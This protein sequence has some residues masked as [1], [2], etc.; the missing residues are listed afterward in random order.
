MEPNKTNNLYGNEF[1][2]ICLQHFPKLKKDFVST[3]SD[4]R[5]FYDTYIYARFDVLNHKM[6]IS[7]DMAYKNQTIV[8]VNSKG[9]VISNWEE[10]DV[11]NVSPQTRTYL[12]E[13]L[14]YLNK[15]Y[16]ELSETV[17]LENI[18]KDFN[19]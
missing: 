8:A 11:L 18:K 1:E 15:R 10:C 7:P 6:Y 13:K 12:I 3:N 5:L 4:I 14:N 19:D 16:K 17:K 2:Q 9:D